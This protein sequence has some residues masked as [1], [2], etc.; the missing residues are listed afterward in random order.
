LGTFYGKLHVGAPGA[1][2][3]GGL[4]DGSG[5]QIGGPGDAGAVIVYAYR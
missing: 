4:T 3:P 1:G 5:Q 2:G